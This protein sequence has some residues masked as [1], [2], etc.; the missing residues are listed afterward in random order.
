MRVIRTW[1]ENTSEAE[2]Y[3]RYNG[4]RNAK[5]ILNTSLY[6]CSCIG[7]QLSDVKIIF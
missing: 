7:N 6:L 2:S 4:Y 5:R 3:L 1:C